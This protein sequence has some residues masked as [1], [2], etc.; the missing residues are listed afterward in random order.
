MQKGKAGHAVKRACLAEGDGEMMAVRRRLEP[1]ENNASSESSEEALRT[2]CDVLPTT[3]KLHIG[4]GSWCAD[5][6]C[7]T[8]SY[9]HAERDDQNHSNDVHCDDASFHVH[10]DTSMQDI[11]H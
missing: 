1:K 5:L 3:F 10:Y 9:Q 7:C 4:H 2:K 11:N 8:S 6:V